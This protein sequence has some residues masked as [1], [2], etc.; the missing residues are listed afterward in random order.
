M[1]APP[2][3][4]IDT[5]DDLLAWSRA[6]CKK[7]RREWLVDVR[8]D[9]VEWEISTRAKRRAAA[10]KRPNI[11]EAAV[12]TPI[13][14]ETAEAAGGRV[15]DGR[16]FPATLSLTW[17]AFDAFDRAEWEST[18]RHELVHL[19]QYQRCGTTGHGSAFEERARE[20][21]TEIH[22]ESFAEAKYVL[23]CE[24]CDALVARRY[25]D[26]KLVRRAE[27]YRSSCCDAALA[28]E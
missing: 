24:S 28:V 2:Y 27:E 7:V 23:R 12:G 11:P 14:W 22:C 20:L 6:Y 17:D 18:L 9:L 26:C 5:H 3:D 4:G 21:D 19:E 8:F 13:D 15:A 16:P 1:T 10:L 25:R